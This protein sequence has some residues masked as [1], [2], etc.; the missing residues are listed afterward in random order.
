LPTFVAHVEFRVTAES[1]D[2]GGKRLRE[3]ANAADSV[4]FEMKTGRV[5]AARL[6]VDAD[7][8]AWTGYAPEER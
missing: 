7:A 8:D 5:E 4:G 2:A 1:V 6:S 3:L